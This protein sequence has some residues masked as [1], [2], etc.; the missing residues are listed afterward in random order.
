MLF[1]VK[2]TI[3]KLGRACASCKQDLVGQFEAD[4]MEDAIKVAKE[5]VSVDWDTH[6]ALIN[7]V[8]KVS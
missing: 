3:R 2:I 7:Y 6:Q 4:T 8:R 1:D 5:S